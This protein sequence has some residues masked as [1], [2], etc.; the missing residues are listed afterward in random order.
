MDRRAQARRPPEVGG[1][2]RVPPVAVDA[3]DAVR[4]RSGRA[5]LSDPG[6]GRGPAAPRAL[7]ALPGRVLDLPAGHEPRPLVPGLRHA[8][9]HV[10]LDRPAQLQPADPLERVLDGRR[11]HRCSSPVRGVA[12]QVVLGTALA[13]FFNQQLRGAWIV[14]GI[15]IL[16]MLLTP[17]VV[18]L[19]WRAL[20][21][22][23]WGLLNWVAVQLGFGYVGW[24]SDPHVALWTLIL[25]DSWQWTPFVFVIVYAR[26]QALP[27]EVF[28]AGSVDGANWFQ[29]TRVPDAAAARA[30]D[31]LRGGL[32]RHRRVPDVRPRL[33]PD[34][35]RP[36][37]RRPRRSP[38]R[39]SRTASS[40]STTATRRR[41]P[42]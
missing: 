1:P 18:G 40:S 4:T 41:S 15:L 25:V 33:R 26:L 31:R 10:A 6:S 39:R 22:P 28:E 20:L 29:R 42:T 13:L 5:R 8:G 38:S 35:R 16:P 24:L 21:N 30:G 17:I 14:R 37:A 32:P 3:G 9:G 19:M 12:I 2:P 23:E 11:E 27:Q 34:E 7:R 36:R